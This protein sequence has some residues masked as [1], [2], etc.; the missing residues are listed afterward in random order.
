MLIQVGGMK[1]LTLGPEDGFL[2]GKIGGKF[3]PKVN[4]ARERTT[5]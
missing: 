2:N 5:T 3:H 4:V 1:S